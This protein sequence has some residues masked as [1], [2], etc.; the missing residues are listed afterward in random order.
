MSLT[1]KAAPTGASTVDSSRGWW[2]LIREPFT[3]AW[4]RGVE[5]RV[6][7]AASN[8]VLFRCVS[9]IASDVSKL[10]CRIVA[11]DSDG[12]WTEAEN[13][14]F[15]PVLR[16][17]N[18]YENRIQFFSSWMLSK[19][20]H[21]NTYVLKA[22]DARSVVTA[23]YVLDPTRVKPMVATDG[24][25]WYQLSQ[26]N[27]SRVG[28]D[29]LV[30]PASE[31]IHD[32]WNTL[33]HPLCGLSPIYACGMTALQGSEIQKTSTLFFKNGS[34]PGGVLTHPDFIAPD[35]AKEYKERWEEAYGGDNQGRV[36]VL[37]NGLKYEAVAINNV[38][39]QL[40]EQLKWAGET[41]CGVYGVPAYMAGV[42]SAPLNNNVASLAQLYYGQCLQPLIESIEECIDDGL[43]LLSAK[44]GGVRYGVEFDLTDLLRMDPATQIETLSKGVLGGL[45]KP[46][47]GRKAINRAPVAGGDSVFLQQQNYSLEALA[48]RDAKEDPFG[49]EAAPAAPDVAPVADVAEPANDDEAEAAKAL[50]AMSKGLL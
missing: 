18:G 24:S 31:I 3:G 13:P 4:Q 21:G 17:P 6:E 12:I 34:K 44:T 46:N 19:L 38:D 5:V 26:D 23:M 16:K 42:G 15:S 32:R 36:A 20:I 14:A 8:P 27:L 22:R 28:D 41:I 49:T 2:P 50:Y 48:K 29:Q 47:E 39:S 40:V 35:I 9:L 7:T 33:Y 37:G 10:R 45:M 30:V 43:G 25:V 1:P 11:L